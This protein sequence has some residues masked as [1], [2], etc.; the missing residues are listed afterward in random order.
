MNKEMSA[1][2]AVLPILLLIIAAS[3][4][5]FVWEAGMHMPLII[6]VIVAATIAV[7]FGWQWTEVQSMMGR[8]VERALPAVFILLIIGV[9]VGSWIASGEIGRASCRERV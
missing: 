6:G 4:S 2:W 1:K 8:G 3:M 9:I 5:V 7:G